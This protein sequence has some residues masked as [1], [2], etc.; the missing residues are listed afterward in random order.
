VS[1]AWLRAVEHVHGH[2]GWLTTL[3]LW[4]PAILLRRARRRAVG[5]AAAATG[6][7]TATAAA[8]ALI[9]PAYR[10]EVKPAIFAAS[11]LIGNL[12]ERK[13]H[14]GVAVVLL[15]WTG[16]IVHLNAREERLDFRA[17]HLAFVAYVGAAVLAT[18]TAGLGL[19][20]AVYKTF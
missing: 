2:L 12:F 11:P 6:L 14:L 1:G 19:A 17:P 3:A 18:F 7:A 13:E 20:V 10:L 9:Y 5:A 15:A 4:H 8:G 16:L